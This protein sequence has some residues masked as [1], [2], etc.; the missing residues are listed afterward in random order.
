MLLVYTRLI[1]SCL[2]YGSEIYDS[3]CKTNFKK[4]DMIQSHCMC[5]CSGVLKSTLV[6]ALQVDCVK[7][8]LHL[9]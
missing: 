3:A 4:L 9:M 7:M 5:L 1:Q 8:P 2:D 6:T